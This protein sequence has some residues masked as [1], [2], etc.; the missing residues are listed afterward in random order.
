MKKILFLSLCVLFGLS[1]LNAQFVGEKRYTVAEVFKFG[2][3]FH[4]KTYVLAPQE[5]QVFLFINFPVRVLTF[6]GH[7]NSAITLYVFTEFNVAV[8]T[9]N[10]RCGLDNGETEVFIEGG[11]PPYIV[12]LDNQILPAP[13]KKTGMKA[14]CHPVK[15]NDQIGNE[16]QLFCAQIDPSNA[17]VASLVATKE[18]CG[19]K[20]GRVETTVSGG[21]TPYS[22]K[23]SNGATTQN[24]LN[25]ASGTYTVTVTDGHNCEVVK[26]TTVT[27][28]G[29]GAVSDTVE[30]IDC[31]RVVLP[32][33]AI[34]TKSGSS[35]QK[36]TTTAG[37]DSTVYYLVTIT[38][39]TDTFK[40]FKFTCDSSL[41]KLDTVNYS[42]KNNCDSTVITQVLFKMVS[43]TT[44]VSPIFVCEAKDT[45]F[46]YT[47]ST[48][49]YKC[50]SV[51]KQ[52]RKLG[53]KNDTIVF[54]DVVVD[55]LKNKKVVKVLSNVTTCD[56]TV[57]I[58]YIYHPPIYF[59]INDIRHECY[60]K[61][62]SY[63]ETNFVGLGRFGEDSFNVQL[64]RLHKPDVIK[65]TF[66]ACRIYGSGHY[67]FNGLN[68]FGCDSTF[69][70]DTLPLSSSIKRDTFYFCKGQGTTKPDTS[71]F[72]NYLGCDSLHI[73]VGVELKPSYNL[74]KDTVCFGMGVPGKDTIK[75]LLTNAVGCDSFNV[76]QTFVRPEVMPTVLDSIEY[77]FKSSTRMIVDTLMNRYGCDSVLIYKITTHEKPRLKLEY[78]KDLDYVD[79]II[80]LSVSGGTPPYEL[81]NENGEKID[82]RRYNLEGG[83]YTAIVTD[84]NG[85]KDTIVVPLAQI[86][87]HPSG[88]GIILR[89]KGFHQELVDYYGSTKANVS[90]INACGKVLQTRIVDFSNEDDIEFKNVPENEFGALIIVF[91]KDVLR[92]KFVKF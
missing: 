86:S 84:A 28:S 34:L 72:K 35:F 18:N 43:D 68:R 26:S 87:V 58:Y 39:L 6:Q 89:K 69:I 64:V 38:G 60:F 5:L 14:G 32:N 45:G 21:V 82:F 48:S 50:D 46:V 22:F 27:N 19:K 61:D 49:V 36:L 59:R 13:W 33:G 9:S 70:V 80:E 75:L 74:I 10:T 52:Y 65:T 30:F 92:K 79:G 20:D 47:H 56:S 1:A 3:V 23:W 11:Q 67:E 77:A 12:L 37:C 44:L 53:Y 54:V 91:P 17:P 7:N 63:Y 73:N 4:K 66:N 85:G 8:Q 88:N 57:I 78:K 2:E 41:V 40:V 24:L 81:T 15:V 42:R 71:K 31:K 62:S 76:V 16:Y 55:S 90:L 29:N 83:I 51:S 25:V